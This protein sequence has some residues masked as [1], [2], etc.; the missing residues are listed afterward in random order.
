MS[1][2]RTRATE[3][4]HPPRQQA[5]AQHGVGLLELGLEWVVLVVCAPGG[6]NRKQEQDHWHC[7]SS[8]LNRTMSW[9]DTEV[10]IS[11]LHGA[12]SPVPV[13]VQYGL[14]LSLSQLK[15]K[16]LHGEHQREPGATA[17][18]QHTAPQFFCRSPGCSPGYAS[19]WLTL[20]S[21]SYSSGRGSAEAPGG[22]M[23]RWLTRL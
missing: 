1:S 12:D 22:M 11:P 3:T 9:M 13:E 17:H 21:Q 23:T 4:P 5:V 8:L 2:P 6:Q 16:H 15:V 14:H 7:S 20:G 10:L 19:V 18:V